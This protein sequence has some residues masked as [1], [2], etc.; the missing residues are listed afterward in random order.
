MANL[1]DIFKGVLI[2][3][4][5]VISLFFVAMDLST[6][7]DVSI[8]PNDTQMF[9]VINDSIQDSYE[10]SQTIGTSIQGNPIEVAV[11]SFILMGKAVVKVVLFP[12]TSILPLGYNLIT[13]IAVRMGIPQILI[14]G[15]MALMVF[16]VLFAIL[17]AFNRFKT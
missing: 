6:E 3:S 12:F 10:F 17:N 5:V 1:S 14:Q 15:L 13:E 9:T 7:Y 4:I 8:D 11:D 2:F 16:G